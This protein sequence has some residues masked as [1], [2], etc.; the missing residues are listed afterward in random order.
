MVMSKSLGVPRSLATSCLRGS[1]SDRKTLT[2]VD[3]REKREAS[4]TEKKAEDKIKE[5]RKNTRSITEV[6]QSIAVSK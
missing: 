3:E 4:D 5:K 1:L 6:S 2:L